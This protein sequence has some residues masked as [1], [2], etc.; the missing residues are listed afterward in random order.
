MFKIKGGVMTDF[1][2]AILP[3]IFGAGVILGVVCTIV[4]GLIVLFCI[5]I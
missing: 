5:N 1:K 4:I 2:S 3:C